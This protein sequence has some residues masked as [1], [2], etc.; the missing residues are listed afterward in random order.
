MTA[1]SGNLARRRFL[2]TAAAALCGAAF[3]AMAST[4]PKSITV[5]KTSGC[6][7]CLGWIDHVRKA[8]FAVEAKNIDAG[9]LMKMKLDAGLRA[10]LASCHTARLGHYVIEGHVP[11]REIGRLLSD[12]AD[13]IGL[14]VP[15]MPTGSPGMESG[16]TQD[17][18]DVLLIRKDGSTEVYA[19]YPARD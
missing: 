18:Y 1:L 8:G 9:A 4:T 3:P 16:T 2:M 15:G 13:A 19:S 14:A 10:D 17:A 12:Q 7:C 11:A 6:G 5:W